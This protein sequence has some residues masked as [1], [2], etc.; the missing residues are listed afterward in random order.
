MKTERPE[1]RQFMPENA[2]KV[3]EGQVFDVYQ[4]QQEMYDGSKRTFEKVKRTDSTDIIAITED[5]KI[6]VLE[7]EQPGKEKYFSLPGGSVD[8]GE[9]PM[10][11]A[12]RELLEETG[13]EAEEI[14]LWH[15]AQQISKI[16]WAL[17]IFFAKNCRKVA[18]QE[19]DGGEKIKVM[20][21]GMEEFIEM[22]IE[23]KIKI[24][25]LV[26]KML[27]EKLLVIDREATYE[28]IKSHF[29]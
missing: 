9:E 14:S 2:E 16:D 19:L 10:E 28:K 3:F 17:Y 18:E 23:Q 7:Q 27:Q 24:N 20:L 12:K 4:W 22:V 21:V 25:E 29:L 13:Y 1:S 11:N 15:S 6:I 8:R 26:A 5:G